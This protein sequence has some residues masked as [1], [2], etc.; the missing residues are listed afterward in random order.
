[1]KKIVCLV[2][3]LIISCKNRGLDNSGSLK[4]SYKYLTEYRST[5][6]KNF[7]EKSYKE[8]SKTSIYREKG[9][10]D[11]NYQLVVPL[12]MYLKKYEE[13][14]TLLVRNTTMDSSKKEITLNT[15]RYLKNYKK[16]KNV[17]KNYIDKNLKYIKNKIDQNPKDSLLYVDYFIMKLYKSDRMTALEEVD[18]M[19]M[20]NK[21]FSGLFYEAMLK[22]AIEDY[23]DEYLGNVSD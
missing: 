3:F 12:L 23:P 6:N 17:A 9:L 21:D 14:E 7:L 10:T 8:L 5:K 19:K 20:I 18:S 2:F 22:D 15:I 16:D 13:L 1:M 4:M 11:E